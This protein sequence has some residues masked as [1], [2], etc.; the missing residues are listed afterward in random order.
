LLAKTCCT[1]VVRKRLKDRCGLQ[2]LASLGLLLDE[3]EQS[4]LFKDKKMLQRLQDISNLPEKEK[5]CLLTT[6]DQFIKA[7]KFSLI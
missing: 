4:N 1:N 7:A 2:I 3:T 6:V 5:E